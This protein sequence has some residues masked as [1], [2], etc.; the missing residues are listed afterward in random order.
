MNIMKSL[1]INFIEISYESIYTD[2]ERKDN[3]KNLINYIDSEKNINELL[4]NQEIMNG[5]LKNINRQDKINLYKNIITNYE[6][7]NI[8]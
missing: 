2:E 7:C 5:N 3:I 6:D 8:Q 1:N 4:I